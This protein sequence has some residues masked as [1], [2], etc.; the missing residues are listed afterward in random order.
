MLS[1][2]DF[3]GRPIKCELSQGRPNTPN[4]TPRKPFE[5]SAKPS[6]C[7]TIFMGNLSFDIDDDAV[8]D[9]FK[10]CGDVKHCRWLSDR[11][12]GQFKGCGFIEVSKR[13]DAPPFCYVYQPACASPPGNAARRHRCGVLDRLLTVL[14][15]AV[16]R[17]WFR[18][19]GR[20]EERRRVDGPRVP[21]RL[22]QGS[23]LIVVFF[24]IGDSHAHVSLCISCPLTGLTRRASVDPYQNTGSI[25]L[26]LLL[27][28]CLVWLL[29]AQASNAHSCGR[30]Y[31]VVLRSTVLESRLCDFV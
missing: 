18:G 11:E 15:F 20:C 17:F 9:F 4:K 22:C 10:D 6:N 19:Q 2:E 14:C 12:S 3:H 27:A 26:F 30:T 7:T 8:K 23:G 28:T 29:D 13:L 16:L 31:V 25:K 24:L 21:H 5:Q 1:G